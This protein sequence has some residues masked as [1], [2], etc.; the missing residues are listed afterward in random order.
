MDAIAEMNNRT[1]KQKNKIMFY[2]FLFS[3]II[4]LLYNVLTKDALT[5]ISY[6][7]E[8]F[9]YILLYVLLKFVFKKE[10][11][12]PYLSGILIFVFLFTLIFLFGGAVSNYQILS[13]ILVYIA[14]PFN[15][16]LFLTSASLGLVAFITNF[17]QAGDPATKEVFA[18]GLLT[19]LLAGLSL[20]FLIKINSGQQDT[21]EQLLRDAEQNAE[22]KQKQNAILEREITLIVEQIN[23]VN[24]QIQHNSNSQKEIKIAI[25]EVAVGSQV[26]SEQVS[27]IAENTRSTVHA[28]KQ[29][30]E[31]TK[32]LYSDSENTK[33]IAKNGTEKVANLNRDMAELKML[34]S[35]LN[36]TFENLTTK[37]HET[38]SFAGTIK[39][40]T[41]QTNL[42]AL[43]ASIEAARAGE[44]G[45]GFSV[46]AS[47]IR[48]LAET[49]NK[50]TENI[51]QNLAEVI[52]TNNLALENMTSSASKLT[53]SV[54]A[55]AEVSNYFDQLSL[56]VD[57]LNEKFSNF[58]LLLSDVN[59]KSLNVDSSTT[60]LA[61]I[62]EE[63][64][65]GLHQ[66]SASI[67]TISDD[68]T[69]IANYMADLATSADTIKSSFN[70]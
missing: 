27:S 22:E 55:T 31:V 40:I 16:K 18:S 60:E 29:M 44:A 3:L 12:F 21:V 56:T 11:L 36:S 54:D 30:E 8:L 1:L 48:K 58:E 42:L 43:N 6:G 19:Y 66:M 52:H 59:Q 24:N 41:N 20:W 67:E 15:R 39:D 38:N 63:A 37:I 23:N 17:L 34:I 51:T 4:G 70:A 35:V 64:S 50:A 28:M 2:S 49:T 53:E 61:A 25:Q 13:F 46:V 65:A 14:V 26:Q 5:T 68:N 33:V 32:D 45:K 10:S 9:A 69:K 47:E 62:I 7:A 57:Q